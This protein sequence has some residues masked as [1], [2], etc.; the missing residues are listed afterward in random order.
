MRQRS[1]SRLNAL[2]AMI[3]LAASLSS[4]CLPSQ[5]LDPGWITV[6]EFRH[7]FGPG[8]P[9]FV[10]EPRA[11]LVDSRGAVFVCGR[12]RTTGSRFTS[13]WLIRRSLDAGRNWQTVDDF[14]LIRDGLE[15]APWAEYLAS[16]RFG[17]VCAASR[18]GLI[19]RSTDGGDTWSTVRDAGTE[20]GS[21]IA[22]HRGEL[23]YL[24]NR[25]KL[26]ASRDAGDS[27]EE[28]SSLPLAQ[29][30]P[31]SLLVDSVRGLFALTGEGGRLAVAMSGDQGKT[32][33]EV[34]LL[35]P[36][37]E[38]RFNVS[39]G[40][41]AGPSGT[42]YV[43][44]SQRIQDSQFPTETSTWTF[45]RG[46]N[47]GTSW[48]TMIEETGEPIL[49]EG[50][51]AAQGNALYA[52]GGWG[53]DACCSGRVWTVLK[54]LDGGRTWN[55]SDSFD[56][57]NHNWNWPWAITSDREGNLYVV[58]PQS[59]G[60]GQVWVVRKL[61]AGAVPLEPRFRRGDSD[62]DGSMDLS[63]AIYTL[64]HLFLAGEWPACPDAADA[65]DD[66]A[67]A[68]TDAVFTIERLF[69]GG[70]VLPAPGS[71]DCGDDATQDGLAAC[72]YGATC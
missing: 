20:I 12:T 42:M 32:W 70:P 49:H 60:S 41:L 4:P 1:S 31:R 45:K 40:L 2:T 39:M 54:S 64:S 8:S 44:L 69:L 5:D 16:D 24:A 48:E 67:L 61:Q 55:T 59:P 38:G 43:T 19:R 65:D 46:S 71:V 63:D 14:F 62:A 6:D 66:G 52:A 53:G 27:W 37:G 25:S 47:G 58:G 18:D 68:I 11:I 36:G 33:S 17:N 35:E 34:D 23:L 15:Y 28:L 10:T 26:L 50:S 51:L 56:L 57:F 72:S 7:E 30:P 29:A 22:D 21:L 13:H 9:A 3:A